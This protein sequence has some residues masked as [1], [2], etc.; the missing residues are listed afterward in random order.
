MTLQGYYTNKGL[1][2]AAKIAGGAARLSVTR[3]VAGSGH[4]ADPASATSLPDIQQTLTVSPPTV[5]GDTATLP[6]TLAEVQASDSYDL[7]EL[8]VYASDP[9]EGEILFQ[10]YQLDAAQSI[11]AHGESVL[12]FYLRQSIGARGVTVICSSAGLLTEEELEPIR[13]KV[14]AASVPSRTV[15]VAAGEL[16]SYVSALPRMLTE[17]LTINVGSGTAAQ[18]SVVGFYGPGS[19]TIDG[20]NALTIESS[21]TALY[22]TYCSAA[23]AVK[24]M[25]LR[26]TVTGGS[27][28]DL[29]YIAYCGDIYMLNCVLTGA[30]YD[31]ALR[32]R[33]NSMLLVENCD[34]NRNFYAIDA[35]ENSFVTIKNCTASGNTNGIRSSG[36]VVSLNGSTPSLMGGSANVKTGGIII[37]NDGTLL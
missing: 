3:V 32:A 6:A 12:R 33:I 7:T 8:G 16:Q 37:K 9:D 17:N 29:C 20:N 22:C 25:T 10:V 28:P 15:S 19:L 24:N 13:S 5:S 14:M 1:A 23:V 27:T 30:Q 4:T 36:G 34:F 21:R 26:S 31:M 11:T 18:L 35:G 2:L